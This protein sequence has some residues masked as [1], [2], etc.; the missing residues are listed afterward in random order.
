MNK[1]ARD[2]LGMVIVIIAAII[3]ACAICT[4][5][6]S[7]H[8]YDAPQIGDFRPYTFSC[9]GHYSAWTNNQV[10]EFSGTWMGSRDA[11]IKIVEIK[12]GQ[13]SDD[14]DG[15][16]HISVDDKTYAHGNYVVVNKGPLQSVVLRVEGINASQQFAIYASWFPEL[17]YVKLAQWYGYEKDKCGDPLAQYH[18]S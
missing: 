10:A 14:I 17:N 12:D 13:P 3:A 5:Y 6:A 7:A 1:T 15:T 18:H 4:P 11:V 9:T 2:A 8:P 16:L